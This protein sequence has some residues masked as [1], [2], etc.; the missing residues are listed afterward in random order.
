V[1]NIAALYAE[2]F[3]HAALALTSAEEVA[4]LAVTCF[5][6]RLSLELDD[7]APHGTRP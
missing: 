4:S 5:G 1:V 2:G 6:E 3:V 7:P